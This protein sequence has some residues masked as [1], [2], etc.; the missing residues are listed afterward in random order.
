MTLISTL[1]NFNRS[2]GLALLVAASPMNAVYFATVE[3]AVYFVYKIVRRDLRLFPNFAE[4]ALSVI[5]SVIA[6]LLS[7]VVTDFR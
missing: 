6:R 2:L 7:K 4:G 1:H 5:L 3:I